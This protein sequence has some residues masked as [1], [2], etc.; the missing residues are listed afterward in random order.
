MVVKSDFEIS[1]EFKYYPLEV[2]CTKDLLFGSV[3]TGN[4]YTASDINTIY[5]NIYVSCEDGV[6][7][8]LNNLHFEPIKKYR[9]KQLNNILNE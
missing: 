2:I 5:K 1:S 6:S 8:W 7:R 3:L 9:N 4:K